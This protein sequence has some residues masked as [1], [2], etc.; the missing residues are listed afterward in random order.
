MKSQKCFCNLYIFCKAFATLPDFQKM[1]YLINWSVLEM[2]WVV[3]IMNRGQQERMVQFIFIFHRWD[4]KKSSPKGLILSFPSHF[5][6]QMGSTGSWF[7]LVA[8][9]YFLRDFIHTFS[10]CFIFSVSQNQLAQISCIALQCEKWTWLDFQDFKYLFFLSFH[11]GDTMGSMPLECSRAMQG[12][13]LSSS[14]WYFHK[15]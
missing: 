14:K 9:T 11:K 1:E 13:K 6:K 2:S 5:Q 3:T 15:I 8:L 4:L 7:F 12:Q 10:L